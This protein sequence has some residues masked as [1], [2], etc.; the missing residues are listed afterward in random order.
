LG[1][2]CPKDISIAAIDDFPWA[3]AFTP[4]LTTIRQPVRQMAEEVV[5]LLLRRIAGEVGEPVHTVLEASLIV[6]E[7]CAPHPARVSAKPAAARKSSGV[8]R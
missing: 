2:T 4:R 6:R 7:S 5:R 8:K 3:N 1:L